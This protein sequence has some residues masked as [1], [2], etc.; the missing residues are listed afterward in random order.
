MAEPGP[1]APRLS[2]SEALDLAIESEDNRVP[3]EL[4]S[5]SD[6]RTYHELARMVRAMSAMMQNVETYDESADGE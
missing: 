5:A 1:Y 6:R 2:L 4:L 3:L